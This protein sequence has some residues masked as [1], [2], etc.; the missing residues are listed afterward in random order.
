MDFI[1]SG[2]LWFLVFLIP[3]IFLFFLK[4]PMPKIKIDSVF[5]LKKYISRQESR[6]G[7]NATGKSRIQLI[8]QILA[9]FALVTALSR[10]VVKRNAGKDILIILDSTASMNTIYNGCARFHLAAQ[11]ASKF[12]GFASSKTKVSVAVF[13]GELKVVQPFTNNLN[14][15]EDAVMRIKPTGFTG[16]L[17]V[18]VKPFYGKEEYDVV[19]FTDKIP[20]FDSTCPSNVYYRIFDAS[21]GNVAITGI[22]SFADIQ[23]GNIAI[24]IIIESDMIVPELVRINL[25]VDGEKQS[26]SVKNI[27]PMEKR[28]LKFNL[29]QKNKSSIGLVEI[30]NKDSL[31]MDNFA[32]FQIDTKK[33][34]VFF[35]GKIPEISKAV[36]SCSNVILTDN[37]T[38]KI[39]IFVTYGFAL[40]QITGNTLVIAPKYGTA[41]FDFTGS[42][43]LEGE[44]AVISPAHPVIENV[45][46]SGLG[47]FY[48]QQIDFPQ[49]ASVVVKK[50]NVPLVL[51]SDIT[52]SSRFVILNFDPVKSGFVKKI[53]FPVLMAN[54]IE[55]LNQKDYLLINT[56]DLKKYGLTVKNGYPGIYISEGKKIYASLLN[57]NESL[58]QTNEKSRLRDY[59]KRVNINLSGIFAVFGL[60]LLAIERLFADGGLKR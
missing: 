25:F 30:V 17:S 13:D 41:D 5:F 15:I 24:E 48:S 20:D 46:F 59:D 14:L 28:I 19:I 45:S 55:W 49:S 50:G 60:I 57:R 56:D 21:D 43:E 26:S 33:A 7:I 1:D 52:N 12:A 38:E 44:L 9:V 2:N 51:V 39:D 10:P 47:R 29:L 31:P 22:S 18:A 32:Y 23:T 27:K 42:D 35:D 34:A 40:C 6:H 8:I 58:S 11:S 54:V 4:L 16:D 36:E 53:S 3:V 37:K